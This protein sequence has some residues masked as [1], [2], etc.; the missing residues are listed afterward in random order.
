MVFHHNLALNHNRN[1]GSCEGSFEMVYVLFPS[2]F[3]IKIYNILLYITIKVAW[4]SHCTSLIPMM[5]YHEYE[6][7]CEYNFMFYHFNF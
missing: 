5:I 6:I 4:S 1:C 3:Q 2:E 7:V